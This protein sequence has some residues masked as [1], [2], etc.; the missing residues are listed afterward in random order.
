MFMCASQT[1]PP[2]LS[3][4]ICALHNAKPHSA[5][6]RLMGLSVLIF[7]SAGPDI[8]ATA[9]LRQADQVT[10]F[11]PVHLKLKRSPSSSSSSWSASITC[12]QGPPPPLRARC[13]IDVTVAVTI[14]MEAAK[15]G[16]GDKNIPASHLQ[17][18]RP[19]PLNILIHVGC[20]SSRSDRV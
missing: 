9:T 14:A 17:H 20:I 8:V 7:I 18:T 12:H 13:H 3:L 10:S 16:Y 6:R 15:D 5:R 1:F 2:E 11:S 19:P 4:S